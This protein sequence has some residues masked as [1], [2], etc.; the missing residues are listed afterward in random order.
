[1]EEQVSELE[2][3]IRNLNSDIENYKYDKCELESEIEVLK[4]S[5]LQ[6]ESECKSVLQE[7]SEVKNQNGSLEGQNERLES[8]LHDKKQA[9]L[10]EQ[11]KNSEEFS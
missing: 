2:T 10:E 1:M 5:L 6:S 9:L 7:L 4:S 11:S 3:N 8:A